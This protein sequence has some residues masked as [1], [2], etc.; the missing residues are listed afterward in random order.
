MATPE[1]SWEEEVEL[2][3]LSTTERKEVLRML[4]PHR[5]MWDGRLGA[6]SAT[7]HRIDLVPGA[8]PVHAQP[9]RAG[10]RAREVEQEEI[11]KML[12][13]GVIEPAISE[14]ASPIVLVPKPD[15]SLR[16]C[17]DYR[18]LNAIT[19]PDTY[20]LPRIY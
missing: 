17:V 6:V 9:Y 16:F 20:P 3:H 7:S 15:G 5:E 4:R 19:V 14:W 2:H 11:E 13:Q 18:R 12:T 8:R 10:G 1:R